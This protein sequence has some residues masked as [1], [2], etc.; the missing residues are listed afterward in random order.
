MRPDWRRM[1]FDI[2][3]PA[4]EAAIKGS[5]EAEVKIEID[6]REWRKR[7]FVR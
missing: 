3:L 7:D 1:F 2:I 6:G 4:R 5:R